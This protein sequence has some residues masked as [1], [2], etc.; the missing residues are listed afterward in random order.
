MQLPQGLVH[1]KSNQVCRLT[2]SLYGLKQASRQWN[3]KLTS[4]LCFLGYTQSSVDHSLFTLHQG[5]SF[6]AL[7]VY[8][9]DIV[10]AGNTMEE[11]KRV[12]SFLD[13]KFRIKDLG[14]L[15]FFLGL[16][17]SRSKKGII[18][19][20]RKYALELLSDSGMLA[21]K[22]ASTPL[23]PAIKLSCSSGSPLPDASSFRRLIGRL[24]YLTTTRPDLCFSV[25]QLSQYVSAPTDIHQAATHRVL[26][27]IKSAP[28]LGLFFPAEN[29]LKLFGYSDSDWACCI[30]TRISITGHCV[31]LG[32]A[33]VS[34]KSKKQ[35]TVLRSSCEAEYRALASL[36]CELQWLV[37]LL[38]D[39]HLPQTQAASVFC[40]NSSA[41]YLAHNLTFHECTKHVEIDCHVVREKIHSNLIHLLP[42]SSSDQLVD[43][44]TKA[45]FA[46][47]FCTIVSKL[48]LQN[49]CSPT[50]RGMLSYIPNV[51]APHLIKIKENPD[52]AT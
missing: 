49:L 45:L 1:E 17:I 12:K 16:E 46:H 8:V 24:L 11:I 51:S 30:D 28:G 26:R 6:T 14:A 21:A 7:L 20:Q 25:Q 13:Q 5:N 50:C 4:A 35:T 18:L 33:L 23:D 32:N 41:I 31:F 27:Y 3:S 42:V 10:L 44:F 52:V 37:Y 40:D 39:L 22:P 48:G 38:N 29:N 47:P 43:L 2:K 15:R 19:N 36:T 9:D 34:W